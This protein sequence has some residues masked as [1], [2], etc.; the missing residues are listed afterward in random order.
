M[1]PEFEGLAERLDAI[2]EEL[3]ELA[4]YVLREAI[5]AGAAKADDRRLLRARRSVEKAAALL[6]E[7]PGEGPT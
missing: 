6:R 1:T 7:D 2:A 5:D 4:I 3:S